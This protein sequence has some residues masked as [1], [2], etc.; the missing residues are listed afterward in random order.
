M[1][2]ELSRPFPIERVGDG[3]RFVVTPTEAEREAV[4][5]RMG[6]VALPAFTC[7]FEL[8]RADASNIVSSGQLRAHV[9]QT[10]VVSLE[11]FEEDI[12]E[13]FLV[14]FVPEG[15]ESDELD[16]DA[17][18]EIPFAGH[19][20][21]LGEAASEQLALALDPFPRKPGVSLPDEAAATPD[22]PFAALLRLRGQE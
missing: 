18:D 3:V 14:R 16:L 11:P 6:L 12:E 17:E 19:V 15:T 22:G 8:R 2:P 5:Q 13:D 1:T 20:I 10:C 7:T 21:D 9:V 4:A